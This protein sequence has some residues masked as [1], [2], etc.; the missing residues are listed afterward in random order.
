MTGVPVCVLCGALPSACIDRPVD[1][2]SDCSAAA[3]LGQTLLAFVVPA[4]LALALGRADKGGSTAP[5]WAL[6]LSIAFG[7]GA[8]GLTFPTAAVHLWRRMGL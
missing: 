2:S 3:G 8:S 6:Y 7:T 5:R 4:L 1:A